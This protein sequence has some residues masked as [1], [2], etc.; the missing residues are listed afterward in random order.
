MNLISGLLGRIWNAMAMTV[1]KYS[2][3]TQPL[4]VILGS[5]GTGKS[6]LAIELAKRFRGEVINA[7]AMQMYRGL[8]VI[9]NKLPIA[10]RQGIPHH[11]LDHI[12]LSE[13]TWVVEDFKREATTLIREIRSRGKLPIVVG[14]THYYTNALLFEDILVEAE[15]DKSADFPILDEPTE[16][17]L[18]KLKEVDP[19]MAERW[20]PNDRRKIRRSLQIYLRSRQR[21]SDIYAEQRNKNAI[22]ATLPEEDSDGPWETLLLWVHSDSEILKARLDT[23]VDKMVENG[24]MEEVHDLYRYLKEQRSAGNDVDLTRGIWQSIGFKEFQK[25]LEAMDNSGTTDA[26]ED[27][28]LAKLKSSGIADV[29]TATRRYAGYQTKWI[30]RKLIPLLK[31]EHADAYNHLFVFDSTDVSAWSEEVARPATDI[32]KLFLKGEPLPIPANLSSAAKQV[33]EGASDAT[34]YVPCRKTCELCNVTAL[35]EVKWQ[36]H[37]RSHRHKRAV[38]KQ[39]KRALVPIPAD[40]IQKIAEADVNRTN[41][42]IISSINP[43]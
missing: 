17:I 3:P 40:N 38:V 1:P 6:D 19:I 18:A 33:L 9:T 42:P 28:A 41:G 15:E 24:L 26:L 13:E 21:A 5:T 31:Q 8:P 12:A 22:A 34:E 37:L 32:T 23:R 4:V 10:D 36:E 11:L 30:R 29:K 25:Y 16:V 39:K 43:P 27:K 20:H 7:D 35:Y 2:P 14:G